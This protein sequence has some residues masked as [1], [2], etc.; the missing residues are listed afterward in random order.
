MEKRTTKD[1]LAK[2]SAW[3]DSLDGTEPVDDATLRCIGGGC[4]TVEVPMLRVSSATWYS[5]SNKYRM[6]ARLPEGKTGKQALAE[7]GGQRC[8]DQAWIDGMGEASAGDHYL[9]CYA[10]TV[11]LSREE[12]AAFR[13]AG[14]TTYLS[15]HS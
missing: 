9:R 14:G 2:L 7:S 13:A 1:Q 10:P 12:W 15:A 11:E 5:V 3:L 4:F 8:G 6:V